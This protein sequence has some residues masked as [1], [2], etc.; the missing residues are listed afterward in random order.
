MEAWAAV[1]Q[2]TPEVGEQ[3]VAAQLWCCPAEAG[4][5]LCYGWPSALLSHLQWLTSDFLWHALPSEWVWA[6]GIHIPVVYFMRLW[7]LPCR[8]GGTEMYRTVEEVMVFIMAVWIYVAFSHLK[9]VICLCFMFCWWY[10][11]QLTST[12]KQISISSCFVPILN[13]EEMPLAVKC[14]NVQE[15]HDFRTLILSLKPQMQSVIKGVKR[16][17]AAA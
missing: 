13:C 8:D 1:S 5:L 17:C 4:V 11:L 10:F 9:A 14:W 7:C 6:L 3:L 15:E 16:V 12:G 2:N